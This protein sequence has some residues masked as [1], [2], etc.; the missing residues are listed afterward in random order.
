MILI[1]MPQFTEF[2]KYENSDAHRNE[3]Y[4]GILKICTFSIWNIEEL[5]CWKD[6]STL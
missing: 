3:E 2:E 1:K 4:V 5:S 6:W